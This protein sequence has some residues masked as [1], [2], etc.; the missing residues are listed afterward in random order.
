[1]LREC[2]GGGQLSPCYFRP[3]ASRIVRQTLEAYATI[4]ESNLNLIGPGTNGTCLRPIWRIPGVVP[5]PDVAE[6]GKVQAVLSRDM[7]AA[8][9][10]KFRAEI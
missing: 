7:K 6:L 10:C 3:I 5:T 1:M 2:S 4:C 8:F 9:E